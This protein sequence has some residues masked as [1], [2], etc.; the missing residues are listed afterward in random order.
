MALASIAE[1]LAEHDKKYQ[2]YADFFNLIE[3]HSDE[4]GSLSYPG[5]WVRTLLSEH[6]DKE[7][8]Y[9]FGQEVLSEIKSAL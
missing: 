3:K 7:I 2:R 5:G 4:E 6:L 9:D 1:F 8:K